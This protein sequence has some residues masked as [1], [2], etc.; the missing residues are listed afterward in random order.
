VNHE[1]L[2][3]EIGA[4]GIHVGF[5]QKAREL[6]ASILSIAEGEEVVKVLD[7]L[8]AI[9]GSQPRAL[10]AIAVRVLGDKEEF[11]FALRSAEEWGR[12]REKKAERRQSF[13]QTMRRLELEQRGL[14][15]CEHGRKADEWCPRCAEK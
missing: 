1:A 6:A 13:N 2:V 10:G 15:A 8:D 9:H 3:R 5:V 4:R 14:D 11:E 12:R 7:F